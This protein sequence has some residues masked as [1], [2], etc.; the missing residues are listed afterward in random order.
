MRARSLGD[1]DGTEN[2]IFT[3][4]KPLW[5]LFESEST[6]FEYTVPS[7]F[8]TLPNGEIKTLNCS[9]KVWKG[10]GGDFKDTTPTAI[11]K[12]FLPKLLKQIENAVPPAQ[13]VQVPPPPIS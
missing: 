3:M 2:W 1:L 10:V 13:N 7:V 4:W 5:Q 8:V 12:A 6:I 9:N 11:E